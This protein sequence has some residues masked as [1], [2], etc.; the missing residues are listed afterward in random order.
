MYTYT[1]KTLKKQTVDQNTKQWVLGNI[2]YNTYTHISHTYIYIYIY[3]CYIQYIC[4][5][6]TQ[7]HTYTY[8]YNI[9]K[10]IVQQN[11]K[12]WVLAH[13]VHNTYTHI[14]HT[15]ISIHVYIT[16]KKKTVHQNAKH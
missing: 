7:I 15:Y 5:H 6:I 16:C 14:S 4:T 11:A 13:M 12:K 10:K 1:Q 9:Q 2:T 8:I 3:I